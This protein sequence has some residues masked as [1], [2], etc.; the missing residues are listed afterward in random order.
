VTAVFS[1]GGITV[2]LNQLSD[3][4]VDV[5]HVMSADDFWE[6]YALASAMPGPNGPIFMSSLGWQAAGLAGVV[7]CV[8]AWALPTLGAMYGLGQM[9]DQAEGNATIGRLL[10][11]FKMLAVGLIFAG[12]AAMVRVFDFDSHAGFVQLALAAVGVVALYRSW[13][14]PLQVL[15]GCMAIGLVLL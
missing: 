9:G 13:L 4:F 7:V 10:G 6:T 8:V 14:S 1:F 12:V 11:V 2:V 5:L 3:V 15:L